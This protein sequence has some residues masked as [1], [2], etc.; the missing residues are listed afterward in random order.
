MLVPESVVNELH[1]HLKLWGL[2]Q[3]EEEASYFQWQKDSLTHAQIAK[4]NQ[5]E[6][7]RRTSDDSRSDIRF[8]DLAADSR[9]L[10]VLYSQRYELYLVVG[11][12]MTGRI[13]PAH[14]VLDFGCG[15][16]ILTTFFARCFPE[17][18]FVG[19]D[20]S[21]ASIAMARDQAKKRGLTNVR[22]EQCEIPNNSISGFFDLIISTHA[23]F[24]AE[25]DPGLPSLNWKTFSR[26]QDSAVQ[27]LA[28]ARVGL[29]ERLDHIGKVLLPE[30]RLLL[31]EKAGHL[32]RRLL[33]QRALSSRGFQLLGDPIPFRYRAIDEMVDDGPLYEVTRQL[34]DHAVPWPEEP[35]RATGQ[36][37]FFCQGKVAEGFMAC[38]TEPEIMRKATISSKAGTP[39]LVVV[40]RW[41]SCLAYGYVKT[42]AGFCGA[43]IGSL[44]DEL[45]VQKYFE[46]CE[47]WGEADLEDRV[48]RWWPSPDASSGST[49]QP[50]FENHTVSAQAIWASLPHRQVQNEATFQESDGREMH[51]EL[52]TCGPL[53]Y[54]YWANTY[55]QRQLVL[56][57]VPQL[58][59]L[60]EY[61]QESISQVESSHSSKPSSPKSR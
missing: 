11:E 54:L 18:E 46:L 24:Q 48:R 2:R 16:G 56:V 51:I 42:S 1:V 5:F 35:A 49:E 52:G 31:C 40:G 32:G 8:Y 30:G 33:L 12:A 27:V 57:P 38:L 58:S 55:D 47:N 17:I 9:I 21:S 43:I 4:L 19:I 20:R 15:V 41:E 37:V 61:Y 50:C 45:S 28:E 53:G 23:L 7:D 10:P 60:E 26:A 13:H 29:K 3:F 6:Q 39:D 44:E 59:M 22:F 34:P 36:S 14:R 25:Q